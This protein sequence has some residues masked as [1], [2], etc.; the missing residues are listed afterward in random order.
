MA[1]TK[2][3]PKSTHSRGPIPKPH[4]PPHP[5]TRPTYDAK[6]HP[7]PIRRFSQCT[8]QTDAQSCVRTDAPTDRPTDRPRKSLIAIG[9]CPT[10]ATRP[11]NTVCY[12]ATNKQFQELPNSFLLLVPRSA[13]NTIY[14]FIVQFLILKIVFVQGQHREKQST[15]CRETCGTEPESELHFLHS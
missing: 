12:K 2:F 11:N 10:R 9:R 6:R 8:G 3:G 13:K 1:R 14:Y 4:Y 7:D 15:N 5:W